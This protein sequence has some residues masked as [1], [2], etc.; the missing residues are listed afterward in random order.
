[1]CW[2]SN[3]NEKKNLSVVEYLDWNLIIKWRNKDSTTEKY[4]GVLFA[5]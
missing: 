2:F 3:N 1:M 4:S 5:N